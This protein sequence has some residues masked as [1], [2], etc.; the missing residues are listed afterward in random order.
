[1]AEKCQKNKA[2]CKLK[3]NQ[4]QRNMPKNEFLI[5]FKAYIYSVC[6][7]KKFHEGKVGKKYPLRDFF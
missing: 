5:T 1:M 7:Q 3:K 4:H 6:T 2:R